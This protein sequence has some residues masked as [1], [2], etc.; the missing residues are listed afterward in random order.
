[1]FRPAQTASRSQIRGPAD[2]PATTPKIA[3][4]IAPPKPTSPDTVPTADSGKMSAGSVMIRPDHDCWQKNAMLK[5]SIASR[6]G[7]SGTSITTGI[8]TALSPSAILRAKSSDR[9]LRSSGSKTSR[10]ESCP[11]PTPHTESTR[12]SSRAS[13]RNRARRTDT[14][15]ARTAEVPRRVAHELRE[16]QHLHAAACR[17]SRAKLSSAPPPAHPACRSRRVSACPDSSPTTTPPTPAPPRRQ[18]KNTARHPLVSTMH[19]DQRGASTEPTA[20]PALMI[21]IAVERSLRRNPLR[22]HA[23]RGRECPALAHAQ[24]KARHQQKAEA[25][26]QPMQR[27]GHRPPQHDQQ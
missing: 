2:S 13:R 3:P 18:T 1:M 25:R 24:Q 5:S 17:P 11:R 12:S 9:P 23:H 4:P 14:S 19:A 22:D 7:T 10:R 20:V 8:N 27:A 6:T 21:P 16:D 15:A 26:R